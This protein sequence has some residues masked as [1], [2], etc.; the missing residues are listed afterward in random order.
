MRILLTSGPTRQYLDPV[1]FISNASSGTMGRELAQAILDRG[2]QVVIVSGPVKVTYPD[3][4]EVINVETTEQMLA[5]CLQQFPDCDGLIGVAAPCDYRPVEVASHKIRKTGEPLVITLV[6]TEDIVATMGKQKRAD[7]WTLGFALETEDAH[8]RAIGKLQ[9]KL[10]DAVVINSASAIDSDNNS[11]EI[12]NA[13]EQIVMKA[14]GSKA[15][16]AARIMDYVERNLKR[17]T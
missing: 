14:E 1:R 17:G 6:E 8:F 11:I 2:H 15:D 13:D 4:A 9:R 7:Q 3:A 5:E 12:V 10:C 16:V